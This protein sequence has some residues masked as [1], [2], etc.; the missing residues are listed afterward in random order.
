MADIAIDPTDI[1]TS[2]QP[3]ES[4]K[5]IFGRK[6]LLVAGGVALGI[7]A[8]GGAT[9]LIVSNLTLPTSLSGLAFLPKP[10]APRRSEIRIG[11][12][13]DM[14]EIRDG[15]PAVIGTKAAPR[16]V[17]IAPP[18]AIGPK[19]VAAM[20]IP[21]ANLAKAPLPTGFTSVAAS[22]LATPMPQTIAPARV[23][24]V[25]L[26]SSS[27]PQGATR[28]IGAPAPAATLAPASSQPASAEAPKPLAFKP[29]PV[30]TAS[31]PAATLSAPLPPPAP[32][33]SL[34]RAP[35]PKPEKPARPAQV[36][37]RQT[38]QPVTPPAPDGAAPVPPPEDRVEILGVKLPNGSDLKNAVSSIGEALNLPKAF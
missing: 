36:A 7:G 29:E 38:A 27:E 25:A 2:S 14:P 8:I 17:E 9:A 32:A 28:S 20:P 35:E 3:A 13:P 5:P 18:A 1:R 19:Q 23:D 15:V 21:A 10:E 34:A 6:T 26:T 11:R 30:S 33:R 24:T 12:L 37:A 4:A 16:V 31:V 22:H